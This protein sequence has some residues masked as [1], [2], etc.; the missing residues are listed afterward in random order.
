VWKLRYVERQM[1][2]M[3][4]DPSYLG[5]LSPIGLF[6][7]QQGPNHVHIYVTPSQRNMALSLVELVT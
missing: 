7:S 5:T 3:S 1:I 6:T 2:G 4:L